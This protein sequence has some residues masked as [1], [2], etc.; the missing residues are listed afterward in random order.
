MPDCDWGRLI[1]SVARVRIGVVSFS[2]A[3][4]DAKD[5]KVFSSQRHTF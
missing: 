2:W 3:E 1:V 4:V 5:A